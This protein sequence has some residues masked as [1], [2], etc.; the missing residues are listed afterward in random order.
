LQVWLEVRILYCPPISLLK[1]AAQ[2]VVSG[3]SRISRRFGGYFSS[4]SEQRRSPGAIYRD[5]RQKSL[6]TIFDAQDSE[7]EK[8]K[9]VSKIDFR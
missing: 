6:E 8:T 5:F 1:N 7:V 4:I 3:K 9:S 2:Y